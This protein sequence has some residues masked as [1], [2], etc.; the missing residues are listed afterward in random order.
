MAGWHHRLHG[1]GF[2]WTLGVGDGQGGLAC[3]SPWGR[4]ESTRL[5]DWTELN[6]YWCAHS[7]AQ[8]F[9]N[10]SRFSLVS[11][12][13]RFSTY[14]LLLIFKGSFYLE[15]NNHGLEGNGKPFQCS[16]LK[17]LMDRGAWRATVHGVTKSRTWLRWRSSHNP[18]FSKHFLPN[19][20]HFNFML[21]LGISSFSSFF[22]F[23][24]RLLFNNSSA[25]FFRSCAWKSLSHTK[26]AYFEKSCIFLT[27]SCYFS[28]IF[29]NLE[30]IFC[31]ILYK[32][33]D[34]F[35]HSWQVIL[36]QALN[37]LSLWHSLDISRFLTYLMT[38]IFSLSSLSSC[39]H[40]VTYILYKLLHESEILPHY[41]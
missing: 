27:Y 21:I 10:Y 7:L 13:A 35:L 22:S 20:F 1:H 41:S 26:L 16:C 6:W 28:F 8:N 29:L 2:G 36:H 30:C 33:L 24:F 34:Y 25:S 37:N 4:K 18:I 3:C 5:S 11:H 31:E 38:H 9:A 15:A 39:G 12:L 14:L 40:P 19:G 32:D 23:L 17:N